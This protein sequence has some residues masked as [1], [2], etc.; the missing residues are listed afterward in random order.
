MASLGGTFDS[1][2]VPTPAIDELRSY[3][4][5]VAWKLAYREGQTK[6]TKPPVNPH[7]NQGASH[8]NPL[9]WGSHKQAEAAVKR[10]KLAGVG[11]VLSTKDD[12]TGIDL[13]NCHDPETGEFAPWAEAII[14]EA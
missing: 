4:S 10:Y 5:W 1:A 13:D 11:F 3:K 8:S 6:P 12:F 7:N 14:A 2:D 9:H